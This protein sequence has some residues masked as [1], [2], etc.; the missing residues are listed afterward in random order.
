MPN[1]VQKHEQRLRAESDI[2]LEAEARCGD[3]CCNPSTQE[4]EVGGSQV[5]HQPGLHS[6]TLPQERKKKINKT[7]HPWKQKVGLA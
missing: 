2:K 4:A 7:K 1:D 6:E 3:S 5:Q